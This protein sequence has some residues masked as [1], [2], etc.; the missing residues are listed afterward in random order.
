MRSP[1]LAASNIDCPGGRDMEIFRKATELAEQNTPFAIAT[2]IE[3]SGSTPRGRAKMLVMHDGTTI[4][5]IG[6]GVVEARVV[7]EARKAMDFDRSIVLD[8]SLD[9]SPGSDGVTESLPMVCGGA[10]KVFVEVFGSKPRIIIVG[11]GHVGL[12]IARAA[13]A[14]GYRVAIVDHRPGYATAEH[15]P[16][17]R[18]LY[19]DADMGT[20]LAAAPVDPATIVV[21]ATSAHAS[22][23][24]A[25]RYFIDKNCRYLGVLGSRRK[26][27]ILEERLR[28]DGIA[29][30]HLVRLKAPIGLDLGAETPEEIAVSVVAEIM[31]NLAGRDAAP[32]SGRDGDLVVVRGAGDL[33]TGTIL[34]LRAAGFRVVALEIEKPTSIRR[35]VSL[36]E[37][38]YDGESQVEGVTARHVSDLA[39][40][41]LAL[42]EGVVPIL[43]DPECSF[44]AALDPYAL[45]DAT[46][47]KRNTGV[48]RGMAPAVIGLGPGFEAGGDVDAVIETQRGHD[49]G[50]VILAGS[51]AP[52]SGTPGEIGG[53]SGERVIKAPVA[54]IVEEVAVIGTMVKAGD[55]VIAIRGAG[56]LVNVT[57]SIAGVV[58]GVIRPGLEVPAG[59]KIADVDPRARLESCMTVSDK[60]RAI[61][62]AVLEAILVLKGRVKRGS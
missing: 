50:R 4:G 2:I 28:A 39:S 40:V 34:R 24:Q 44:V 6:G 31:A 60:A 25:V 18:E 1:E 9:S 37:A 54:G 16:M 29:E 49:L 61:A 57:T 12:H 48:R 35:T 36:S 5:T 10:M 19:V 11:G 51:A 17:A 41:R 32:L 20:A 47:C 8:Y 59:M 45:I 38:V 22:D 13:A 27:R 30:E 55:P 52:D 21:V 7:Q 58:R 26:V 3:S 42:A 53:K 23:E 56:G 46:I 14:V 33:A 15:L 43:V 62:G